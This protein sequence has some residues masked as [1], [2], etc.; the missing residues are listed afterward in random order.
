MA[1]FPRIPAGGEIQVPNVVRPPIAP[2]AATE[3]L[4]RAA[5]DLEDQAYQLGMHFKALQQTNQF[6]RAQIDYI[7]GAA[8]EINS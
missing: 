2:G 8:D 6:N 4:G 7:N 3:A 1:D 5:N